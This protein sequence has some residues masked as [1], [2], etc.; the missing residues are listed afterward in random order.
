VSDP[1]IGKAKVEIERRLGE[2]ITIECY[3]DGMWAVTWP[4]YRY[5][6]ILWPT[7]EE[8]ILSTLHML[9][10]EDAETEATR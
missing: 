4:S 1:E 7:A 10:A 2:R 3:P 8:A 6:L 9:R 5:R